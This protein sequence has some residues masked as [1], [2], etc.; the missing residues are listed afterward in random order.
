MRL[1]LLLPTALL[2]VIVLSPAGSAVQEPDYAIAPVPYSHVDITD[3]F[4]TKKIEV[5]RTVSIQHVF[6][7]AEEQNGGGPAQLIEAAGYML[8]KRADPALERRVDALID[9]IA[10]AIDARAGN[11]DV[12]VRT[13][14]TFLEGAVAY[15]QATGKKKRSTPR[16]KRPTRWCRRTVPAGRPTSRATRG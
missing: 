1:R 6:D 5:N 10:A 12:S 11:A 9:R 8:A 13:S 7:R 4:W 15:F 14:G 3:A 16:S 2:L